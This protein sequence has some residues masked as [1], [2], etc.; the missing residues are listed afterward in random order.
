VWMRLFCVK[1][2]RRSL[3]CLNRSRLLQI[4]LFELVCCANMGLQFC[5]KHLLVDLFPVN[6]SQLDAKRSLL[7]ANGSLLLADTSVLCQ[8][9]SLLCVN[10]FL[11]VRTG[12]F[13]L[14]IFC[15]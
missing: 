13:G 4:G 9:T 15:V 11:C 8:S 2:K 12:L 14:L 3:L 10:T 1:H 7:C 5:V 6:R